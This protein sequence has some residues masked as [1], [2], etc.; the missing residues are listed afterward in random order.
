MRSQWFFGI[1]IFFELNYIEFFKR[2][3]EFNIQ[4][5]YEFPENSWDF[6]EIFEFLNFLDFLI[7]IEKILKG[8]YWKKIWIV[9]MW[10]L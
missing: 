9:R 7:R 10:K 8:F 3:I 2:K 1:G 4:F 5:V 6:A